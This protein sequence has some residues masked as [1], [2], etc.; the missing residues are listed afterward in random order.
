MLSHMEFHSAWLFILIL[1]AAVTLCIS[2]TTMIPIIV[3]KAV[4]SFDYMAGLSINIGNEVNELLPF[5]DSRNV[6]SLNSLIR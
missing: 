4:I 5:L 1:S 3:L 2:A 6:I